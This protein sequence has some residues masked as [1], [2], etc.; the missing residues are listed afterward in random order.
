M[1]QLLEEDLRK[2]EE[3]INEWKKPV[4]LIESD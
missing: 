3:E 4:I 2:A 1:G